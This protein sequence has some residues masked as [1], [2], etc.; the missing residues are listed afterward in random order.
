MSFQRVFVGAQNVRV[1]FDDQGFTFSCPYNQRCLDEYFGDYSLQ[2]ID[3]LDEGDNEENNQNQNQNNNNNNNNN[4][5]GVLLW[6]SGKGLGFFK[7]NHF[8][9]LIH[10]PEIIYAKLGQLLLQQ[11]KIQNSKKK[12]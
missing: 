12:N 9:R 2:L 1:L 11:Q 7:L 3:I 10:A 6:W 5:D 4:D 8:V